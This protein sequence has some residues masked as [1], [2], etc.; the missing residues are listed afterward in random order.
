L[1]GLTGFEPARLPCVYAV[2]P[3]DL[4]DLIVLSF[5]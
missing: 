3:H 2:D 5:F 1:V 4:A